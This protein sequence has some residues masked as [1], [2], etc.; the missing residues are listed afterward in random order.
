[1]RARSLFRFQL[2]RLFTDLVH[3]AVDTQSRHGGG[4]NSVARFYHL[5]SCSPD[6]LVSSFAVEWRTD[7]VVRILNEQANSVRHCMLLINFKR[8]A[9]R[10]RPKVQSSRRC[11]NS[12]W[13]RHCQNTE[14]SDT[15]SEFLNDLTLS[16][17]EWLRHYQNS[18]WLRHCQ[19]TRADDA[20]GILMSRNAHTQLF[21]LTSIAAALDH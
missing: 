12:A 21:I 10:S 15:L 16:D 11:Q 20:V 2:L 1:M 7:A 8:L 3:F 19:K 17:S 9:S 18:E 5:A 14:W 6:I 4:Q 13:S